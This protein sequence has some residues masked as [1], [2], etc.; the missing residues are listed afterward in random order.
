M[1]DLCFQTKNVSM[2]SFCFTPTSTLAI[3]LASLNKTTRRRRRRQLPAILHY[4]ATITYTNITLN[5]AAG[6][7]GDFV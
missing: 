6:W 2:V 5:Q 7:F 1:S 4:I 3:I